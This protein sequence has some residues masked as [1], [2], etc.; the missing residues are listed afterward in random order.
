MLASKGGLWA[1]TRALAAE[2]APHAIKVNAAGTTLWLM[3]STDTP[4]N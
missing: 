4:A 1:L 2:G 3:A